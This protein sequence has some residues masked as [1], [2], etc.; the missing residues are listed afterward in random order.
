MT[1]Q[2]QYI[3]AISSDLQARVE[4]SYCKTAQN[5]GAADPSEPN[6]NNRVQLATQISR[7]PVMFREPFTFMVCAQG[8]TRASDDTEIDTM[9]SACWNTMAGVPMVVGTP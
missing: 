7:S 6:H 1:L 8:I 3:E 2:D 5:V 9:V 4:M